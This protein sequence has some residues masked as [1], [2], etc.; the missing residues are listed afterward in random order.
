MYLEHWRLER[1]P[2]E[3]TPDPDFFYFS[4]AHEESYIRFKYAISQN[5]GA[6]LL[7]GDYGCGKTTMIRLLINE[8]SSDNFQF[9]LV[10]I[11]R[12]KGYDLLIQILAELGEEPEDLGITAI[13]RI[14]GARLVEDFRAGKTTVVVVDEAQLITDQDALEE[15]RLLLNFQLNDR[16]L[17]NLFLV[18]QP[19]LNHAIDQMPQ[20]EQRL[21][22]RY[23]LG[24]LDRTE[25]ENY[26]NHRLGVAGRKDPIFNDKAI[27]MICENSHGI[28]RRI[29]NI[30]DLAL[31]FGATSQKRKID[32]TI[33]EKVL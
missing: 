5:K 11:P 1:K 24:P 21:Y 14:M 6:S 19:E 9:A 13:E 32:K 15:L 2:F 28:P 33:I 31:L 22:T 12:G 8:L 3:N 27:E 18:G 4:P 29:N 17:I 23:H 26:I 30:C 16:F 7:T 20:F 25:S 10:N